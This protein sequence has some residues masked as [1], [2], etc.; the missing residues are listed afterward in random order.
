MDLEELDAYFDEEEK[1]L[2]RDASSDAAA[3]GLVR[4]RLPFGILVADE[5]IFEFVEQTRANC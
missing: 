4:S 3:I 2:M 1:E 5:I